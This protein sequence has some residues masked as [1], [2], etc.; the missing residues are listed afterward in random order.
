LR[1]YPNPYTSGSL[2]LEGIPEAF[3]LKILDLQGREV[4]STWLPAGLIK[5]VQPKQLIP[6][7]YLV[8]IENERG[9]SSSRLVVTAQ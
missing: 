6:G 5:E 2:F 8:Q 4:F 1:F 9:R 7:I 3:T